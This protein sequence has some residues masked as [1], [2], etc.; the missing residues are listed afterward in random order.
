MN[1]GTLEHILALGKRL[2]VQSSFPL[3]KQSAYCFSSH[4]F[5]KDMI[6]GTIVSSP[7]ESLLEIRS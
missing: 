6:V 3:R 2:D 1:S 5:I 7:V 4:I